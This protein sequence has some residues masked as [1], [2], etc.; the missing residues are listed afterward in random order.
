[1]QCT[2]NLKQMSLAA[3]NHESSNGF[4]PTGGWGNCWVGDPDRG[5]GKKQPGGW[6]FSLLPYMDQGPLHDLGSGSD[7]TLHAAG[8]KQRMQ[9]ALATFICPSRRQALLYPHISTNMFYYNFSPP[10]NYSPVGKID[11]AANSGT[12]NSSASVPWCGPGSLAAG[13]AMTEANTSGNW[14][15]YPYVNDTGVVFLH[16]ATRL[17]EIID[18]TS[19]TYL[20][21]EKYLNPDSYATG[22]DGS[23]D[24]VW[25]SG[26][27][28]DVVRWTGPLPDTT[29]LN[30]LALFGPLQD[31]P[32]AAWGGIFG[33]ADATGFN[34][35]FCDGSTR[36]MPYTIDLVVHSRLGNRKD[37]FPIDSKQ[38]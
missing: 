21:G 17:A 28:G 14:G 29:D 5:Y 15:S 12:T 13:D 20:I 24:Q 26:I 1:M 18:G 25:D 23:D 19:N 22:Q 34:M 35:S 38:L 27:D 31:T 6:A 2:N 3:L 37:G 11:Y 30:V 32:G 16:S 10:T 8:I 7:P 9:T 33:S 4:L 36:F